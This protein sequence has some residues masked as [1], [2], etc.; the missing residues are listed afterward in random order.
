MSNTTLNEGD[1]V[2]VENIGYGTLVDCGE[3][4]GEGLQVADT[5]PKKS[6][7]IFDPNMF[8]SSQNPSEG[9]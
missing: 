5:L 7:V 9:G 8:D 2:Y 6:S 4:K 1:L 3:H